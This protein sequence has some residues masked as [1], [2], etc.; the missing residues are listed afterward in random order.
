MKENTISM[1]S[2]IYSRETQDIISQEFANFI[3]EKNYFRD[4]LLITLK[5]L[6]TAHFPILR[7]FDDFASKNENL[8]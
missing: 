3:W 4:F 6:K 8:C 5:F 7:F 1:S 2:V